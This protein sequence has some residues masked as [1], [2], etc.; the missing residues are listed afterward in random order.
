[1]EPLYDIASR[2]S[3][4]KFDGVNYA[5]NLAYNAASQVET[6]NVGSLMTENYSYDAKT[7]LLLT[8]QV[9][10]GTT[11]RLDLKYN[12][13]L[14]NDANNSGAKTGQ[15]TGVTDL[16]NNSRNKAY[17]YDKLGRLKEARGGSDAFNAPSWTQSYS[18]D[19]Y[20]NRTGVSKTG[21]GAGS[22]PLD[23]LASLAYIN[24]QSQTLTN[25]ITTD[26]YE[27]DPAGNQT[28]GQT[29]NGVWLRSKYDAAGRLAQVLTDASAVLETYG[30]GATNERLV[31]TDSN[32]TTTF[33]AWEGGQVIAEYSGVGANGL[34]WN[35][36]YVY[37][38]GRLLAT[39]SGS[40]TQYYHP[41]RLGTR[42]VTD[43]ATG[44]VTT[45]QVN[46]PF[47]T[48]LG[49]ESSGASNNRRFTSYDRSTNTG[50][51]YAVNRF[52]NGAQGRFTQVDSIG[53]SAASLT[54]PQTLNLY[55]YVGNDPVNRL[56]PTGLFWGFIGKLIKS[57]AKVFVVVLVVAA[58]LI[59]TLTDPLDGALLAK[60]LIGAGIFA[61]IGWGS[62][63]LAQFA[64]AFLGAASGSVNFRT[65]GINGGTGVG[66]VSGFLASDQSRQ[67]GVQAPSRAALLGAISNLESALNDA[68]A[69][70]KKPACRSLIAG[71]NSKSP[72][73][74]LSR[75]RRNKQVSLGD[76]GGRG[77]TFGKGQ[78]ASI[79]LDE[80][81]INYDPSVGNVVGKGQVYNY[82]ERV[83]AREARAVV[84]LHELAHA[85]GALS[86]TNAGFHY[87]DFG[88]NPLP[89]NDPF[90]GTL[91]A[92]RRIYEACIK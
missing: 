15:L 79:L 32:G 13:T 9:K 36:H 40:G 71:P 44:T 30:Y 62:G 37:L 90:V 31:T 38:G 26:G 21:P 76:A 78:G 61:L 52:Y 91:E 57:I 83:T 19:R 81:T 28:R 33:Y 66:A 55:A 8:Q 3:T 51:D 27:Y 23:G 69:A 60:T 63:K 47:G 56:D 88:G 1:M 59:L 14:N 73:S 11:T 35:K 16:L 86:A 12:Y 22:V 85:T 65:P 34:S 25:R 4:L 7:G 74:L 29:E 64:S 46:L 2:V 17:Q 43:G 48:A 18:Y 82:D 50:L 41:D 45:E 10:Q 75:L 53:M 6:L 72:G 92:N 89:G 70:L 58:V 42:L 54:D 39:L 20:G 84:A 77:R 80:H 5:A 24:A 87:G 49:A 68:S 67:Q